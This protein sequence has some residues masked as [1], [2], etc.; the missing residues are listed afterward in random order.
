MLLESSEL[1]VFVVKEM[2]DYLAVDGE[3]IYRKIGYLAFFIIIKN[4]L[5]VSMNMV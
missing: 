2:L 1:I 5:E 3:E 4:Y